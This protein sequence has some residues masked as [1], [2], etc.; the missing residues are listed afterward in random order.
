M[1]LKLLVLLL[2]L[3]LVGCTPFSPKVA[4]SLRPGIDTVEIN[5]TFVDAGAKATV[6]SR[7]VTYEIIY[8]DVDITKIGIY[9]IV[10]EVVYETISKQVSRSV[11]VI[12]ETPPVI[13]LRQG[14][15]TVLKDSV[16]IDAFVEVSDNSNG[17]I[18]VRLEGEVNTAILGEYMITY[19]AKD[20]S[21]NE[22][23]I[24]RIVHVIPAS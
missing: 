11:F 19:Y 13:T 12:D 18:E 3:L 21:G 7:T 9:T 1:K 17:L 6:N 20:Q 16:W 2:F 10:Y 14:I 24:T 4:I 22:S 23:S 5:S 8:N 15:D